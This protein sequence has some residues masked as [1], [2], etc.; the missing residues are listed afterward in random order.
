MTWG[1]FLAYLA[2]MPEVMRLTSPWPTE[3]E[4]KPSKPTPGR[5]IWAL[6]KSLGIYE[7]N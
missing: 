3:D 4:S 7:P 2:A 5:Q 6:S 1:Q